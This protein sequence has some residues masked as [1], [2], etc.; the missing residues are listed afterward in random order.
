MKRTLYIDI[1]TE[2]GGWFDVTIS[3]GESGD[4]ITN[5]FP[6]SPE[7]HP[8]FNDWVGN[9]L[10][11]WVDWMMEGENELCRGFMRE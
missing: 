1:E 7:E 2:P 10:Y 6:F 11:D 4:H 8:E 9:E 3:D 5:T